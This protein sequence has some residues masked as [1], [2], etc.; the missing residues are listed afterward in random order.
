MA[1]SCSDHVMLLNATAPMKQP[2]RVY[3]AAWLI[4]M[5]M[6]DCWNIMMMGNNWRING[7]LLEDDLLKPLLGGDPPFH[8]DV[9]K[10]ML[11]GRNKHP[12]ASYFSAQTGCRDRFHS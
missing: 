4:L 11:Q 3:H 1:S 6:D 9:S 5:M 10:P 8:G 7:E 12:T 2:K